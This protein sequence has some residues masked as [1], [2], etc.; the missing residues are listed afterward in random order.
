MTSAI[1]FASLL[2]RCLLKKS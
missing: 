1:K 2:F